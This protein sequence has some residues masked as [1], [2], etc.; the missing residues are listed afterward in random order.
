LF[1]ALTRTQVEATGLT[2]STQ[3]SYQFE[4]CA[5]SS[6]T[7]PLGK[8]RTAPAKYGKDLDTQRFAIYSCS[9]YPK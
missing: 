2:A 4:N 9:N 5:D 1:S 6:N 3:Y 7:S 8:T